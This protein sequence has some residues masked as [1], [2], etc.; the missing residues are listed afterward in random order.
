MD[1]KAI[2]SIEEWAEELR[3]ILESKYGMTRY[4]MFSYLCDN[5][6]IPYYDKVK[7]VNGV[8]KIYIA[9]QEGELSE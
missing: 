8:F 9:E 3:P 6:T 7:I 4:Y 1:K 2:K 5:Y